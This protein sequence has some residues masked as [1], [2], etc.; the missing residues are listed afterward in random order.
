MHNNDV[1]WKIFNKPIVKAYVYRTALLY[2]YQKNNHDRKYADVLYKIASPTL[3]PDFERIY[4]KFITKTKKFYL[5]ERSTDVSSKRLT[6][7]FNNLF[8]EIGIDTDDGAM[9][10]TNRTI[11]WNE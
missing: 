10:F 4:S 9:P 3:V 1:T 5:A 7:F 11:D 2:Y 8:I 6:T